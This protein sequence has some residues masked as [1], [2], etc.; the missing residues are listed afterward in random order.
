MT[1]LLIY[2]IMSSNDKELLRNEFGAQERAVL[3]KPPPAKV[4][5][6][7]FSHRS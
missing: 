6:I 4:F 7:P 2:L 3:P 5:P 1:E